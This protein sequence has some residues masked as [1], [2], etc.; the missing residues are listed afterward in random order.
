MVRWILALP[1]VVCGLL[2]RR[3]GA[4]A[5]A[6]PLGA[7]PWVRVPRADAILDEARGAGAALRIATWNV[8]ADCYVYEDEYPAVPRAALDWGCRRQRLLEALEALEADLLCLQEVEQDHYRRSSAPHP[9]SPRSP[10]APRPR[11]R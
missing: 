1:R 6:S 7:R 11:P 4:D 9:R 3:A 10:R 5:G 8:L 2:S